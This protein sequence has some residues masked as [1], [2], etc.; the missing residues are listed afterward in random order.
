MRE[1]VGLRIHQPILSQRLERTLGGVLNI[2]NCCLR[3]DVISAA[4]NGFIEIS[5]G[6]AT[7]T[8][9]WM[10]SLANDKQFLYWTTSSVS[11][12][13]NL[14]DLTAGVAYASTFLRVS[15]TAVRTVVGNSRSSLGAGSGK[16][17]QI[18]ADNGLVVTGN[19]SNGWRVQIPTCALTN[20]ELPP[21]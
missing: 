17:A 8:G 21:T 4:A 6:E 3:G 12:V 16:L 13:G 20:I 9:N 1:R 10:S 5:A 7:F 19:Y 18:D 2:S 15:T 11:A 14:F